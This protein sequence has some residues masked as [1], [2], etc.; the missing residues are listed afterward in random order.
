M[1]W[2]R[3]L[4]GLLVFATFFV[5]VPHAQACS[6]MQLPPPL[7]ALAQSDAVFAGLVTDVRVENQ[8]SL[9]GT[10]EPARITFEVQYS[11]KGSSISPLVMN[12][13]HDGAACGF[14]F[15]EGHTYL[16]YARQ[17]QGQLTTSLCTRTNLLSNA[18]PDVAALGPGQSPLLPVVGAALPLDAITTLG[19]A[20]LAALLVGAGLVVMRRAKS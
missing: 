19:A 14:R 9:F 20:A 4:A 11:W 15:E 2:L 17:D 7:E 1:R 3:L 6:C 12:T 10:G 8:G 16:V 18:A 13:P 5:S